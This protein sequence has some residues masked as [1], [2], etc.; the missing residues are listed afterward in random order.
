ML[1]RARRA[2]DHDGDG[3]SDANEAEVS[4]PWLYDS[5]G[6]GLND[7]FEVDNGLDP[8]RHDTDGDGLTD[9]FEVQFGTDANNP[10]T[11][12]DGMMDY[13]EI[14]GWLIQFEYSGQTF[15]ARVYT[16]PS[17]F[18]L[19]TSLIPSPLVSFDLGLRPLRYSI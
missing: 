14:A 15:T 9:W 16:V 4:N 1:H 2:P 11:D 12:G 19:A 13:L 8:T 7:K 10:D 17:S 6:D 18:G 5:D 3:L